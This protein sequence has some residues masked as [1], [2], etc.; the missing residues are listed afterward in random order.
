LFPL[1]VFFNKRNVMLRYACL[2]KISLPFFKIWNRT[3]LHESNHV[4]IIIPSSSP[5]TLPQSTRTLTTL[6]VACLLVFFFIIR[7]SVRIG[8]VKARKERGT[9]FGNRLDNGRS[10]GRDALHFEPQP[11]LFIVQVGFHLFLIGVGSLER[12]VLAKELVRVG[13]HFRFEV[14]LVECQFLGGRGPNA[15]N[16]GKLA[17]NGGR[18]PAFARVG[19]DFG[20]AGIVVGLGGMYVCMYVY[21]SSARVKEMR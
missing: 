17:R 12:Q 7:V 1:T 11:K 4:Y 18:I 3:F 14:A 20:L 10:V 6:Y 9:L 2:A 19:R 13:D 15:G 5:I 8:I 16:F 21:I